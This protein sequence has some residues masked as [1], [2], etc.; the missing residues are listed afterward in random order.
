MSVYNPDSPR[1]SGRSWRSARASGR[2]I[3]GMHGGWSGGTTAGGSTSCARS[4]YDGT[5]TPGI[6]SVDDCSSRGRAQHRQKS[7]TLTQDEPTRPGVAVGS[8]AGSSCDLR[9]SFLPSVQAAIRYVPKD[10]VMEVQDG[11]PVRH[12]LTL[13]GSGFQL[14]SLDAPI[15]ASFLDP[16]DVRAQAFPEV[17]RHLKR[18]T[19]CTRV[20]V[21]DHL[22]R[23]G[24]RLRQEVRAGIPRDDGRCTPLLNKPFFKAHNDYTVRSGHTRARQLLAP[25]ATSSWM[26]DEAL[27]GRFAIINFWYPLRPVLDTPLAMC[28]WGSFG[29]A[30]VR[31]L[32]MTYEH[33]VGE[34]YHM[35]HNHSH[36]WIYFSHMNIDEAILLKTFDSSVDVARFAPHTAFEHVED[37]APRR[38]ASRQSIEFRCLVFFDDVPS[39]LVDQFVA[40]HL[41][42][43]SAD[44]DSRVSMKRTQLLPASNEW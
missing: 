13:D 28:R 30:D 32:R 34:T 15:A 40:P 24:V 25:Y 5:H 21:F 18:A 9:C 44:A 27:S 37:G 20:L 6:G 35:S 14:L 3:E 16:E 41:L 43:G 2:S 11:R 1:A 42:P 26:L 39:D 7:S 38:T 29:P 36:E 17:V 22:V 8:T 31:T 19:G 23:D 10:R 12:D 33:R 4:F